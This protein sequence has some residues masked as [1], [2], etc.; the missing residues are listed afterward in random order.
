[1]NAI[2]KICLR[3]SLIIL[4]GWLFT[5]A[6]V[7]E[8]TVPRGGGLMPVRDLGQY[9]Q[10]PQDLRNWFG[11]LKNKAGSQCC[12]DADGYDAQWD[13]KDGKFRVFGVAGW[14]VVADDAVIHE[15][16]KVGVAKVWW[17]DKSQKVIRC[18]L[19][20]TEG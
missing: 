18:F 7:I 5:P 13:T 12:A 15:P 8:L 20:G 10:V 17:V 14:I 4:I 16:N 19:E 6:P 9:D 11:G 2:D 1:M 3:L